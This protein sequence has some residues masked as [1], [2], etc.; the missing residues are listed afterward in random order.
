MEIYSVK[1]GP[2]LQAF[3]ENQRI[4]RKPNTK[5]KRTPPPHTTEALNYFLLGGNSA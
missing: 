4:Q 2:P 3:G 5:R 1:F